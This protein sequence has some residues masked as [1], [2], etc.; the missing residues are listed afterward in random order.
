LNRLELTKEQVLTALQ[1]K[2]TLLVRSWWQETKDY[3]VRHEILL[4]LD[5]P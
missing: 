2:D 1:H 3:T 4:A 5:M